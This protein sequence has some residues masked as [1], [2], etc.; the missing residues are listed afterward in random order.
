MP[1]KQDSKSDLAT[2]ADLK[3]LSK[4]FDK[5]LQDKFQENTN[6]IIEELSRDIRNG[7]EKILNEVRALRED[8]KPRVT[9]L[10]NKQDVTNL[11]IDNHE[12]RIKKLEVVA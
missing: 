10:E 2:K 7:N 3:A 5:K 1:K 4:T 9:I 12:E 8:I 6:M 11:R